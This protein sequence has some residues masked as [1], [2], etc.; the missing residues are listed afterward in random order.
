MVNLSR[1]E[2]FASACAAGSAAA[3]APTLSARRSLRAESPFEI[4]IAQW[5]FHRTLRAGEMDHLDFARVT[6]ESFGLGA[7]EYVN[8]FFK[9]KATDFGYL[10]EMKRRADDQ[11]VRSLLIMIDGEGS[12]ADVDDKARRRAVENHFRWIA[13]AAFL[14]C[15]SIRVNA[16][17]GGTREEQLGRA[18][19]SLRRL[20]EMGAGYG[21]NVIVENHGGLSSDGSW[22]AEVMRRAD[23][24]GVGTLPDFGN[25]H[26]GGGEWY[27]R[28]RGV[29]ELMPYAKAV[30]AKS[31][32]FDESGDEVKTDYR[33]M[34]E[35]VIKAGYTGYVGIEY[36]G[37][38]HS[39]MEGVRLTKELLERVG[40]ELST[41]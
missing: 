35:I 3:F 20:G 40:A 39:E 1:R 9:D 7:V 21:I 19:S 23:H 29:E 22:L 38:K 31:H 26:L 36:E 34:L 33:R 6:R 18:A 32:E 14:G 10:S 25:F 16:A 13:A 12:L 5:S 4:S 2:L 17:G 37:S 30:S 27:D 15:H 41:G 8:S 24:P 28:Y 11:G